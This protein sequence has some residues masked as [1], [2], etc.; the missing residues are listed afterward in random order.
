MSL[1]GHNYNESK[2]LIKSASTLLV[3]EL[4]RY[5][6]IFFMKFSTDTENRITENTS[7]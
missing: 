5:H 3:N 6:P 1:H 7:W 4:Y 2:S